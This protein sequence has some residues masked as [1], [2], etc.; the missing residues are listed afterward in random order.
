MSVLG[1][2]SV[3]ETK[4]LLAAKDYDIKQVQ[5]AFEAF[6]PEWLRNDP[7]TAADWTSDWNTFGVRYSAA[8]TGAVIGMAALNA[9][10]PLVPE[11]LVP[12]EPFWNGILRALSKTPGFVQR[13]D[14]QDLHNRLVSAQ[15]K[16]VDFSGQ[17][18]PTNAS[19]ADLAVFQASDATLKALGD[20]A[21]QGIDT[22][23]KVLIGLGVATLLVALLKR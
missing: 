11:N 16:P 17:P 23:T 12:A 9:A 5:D 19:D 6:A 14:F 10:S 15:N 2:H 13:G 20:V 4:E 21:V 22:G 18:Q 7:L 3:A 1:F 8:K